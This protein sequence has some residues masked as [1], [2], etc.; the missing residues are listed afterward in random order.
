MAPGPLRIPNKTPNEPTAGLVH[1]QVLR[2]KRK[3]AE[4][5]MPDMAGEA[6]LEE[7]DH[8]TPFR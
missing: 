4:L 8:P 2:K 1:C 5:I 7:V 6:L 3:P